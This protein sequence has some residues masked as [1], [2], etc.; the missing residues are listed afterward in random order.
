MTHL[1]KRQNMIDKVD[2]K[3]ERPLAGPAYPDL[4]DLLSI[5]IFELFGRGLSNR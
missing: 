2:F 3:A 5:S 1:D 4:E